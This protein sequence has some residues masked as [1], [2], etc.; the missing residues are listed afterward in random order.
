[1]KVLFVCTDNF[2]RSV[3]VEFCMKDYILKNKL[4][5]INVASAGIRGNSDI[6]Q[7]SAIHFEIMEELNIDTS[8]FKRT[9]FKE[10]HFQEFDEIIGMSELHKEHIMNE[11]NREIRLFNELYKGDHTSVN[12]GA[13]DSVDF[14]EQM[15]ALVKYFKR[16]V[17]KVIDNLKNEV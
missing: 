5:S 1:M 11:Y 3:I 4:D 17:P 16:A 2:T 8:N 10:E 12:I 15:R 9:Q 7:Y 13:P 14:N 6:S